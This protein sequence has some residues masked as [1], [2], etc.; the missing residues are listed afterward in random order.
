MMNERMWCPVNVLSGYSI[1][2]Q[3]FAACP[4][5]M[6]LFTEFTDANSRTEVYHC[7]LV[8]ASMLLNRCQGSL[9]RLRWPPRFPEYQTMRKYLYEKYFKDLDFRKGGINNENENS[10]RVRDRSNQATV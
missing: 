8:T 2:P 1:C 3:S 10:E 7:E 6:H 9:P 5:Y 4:H